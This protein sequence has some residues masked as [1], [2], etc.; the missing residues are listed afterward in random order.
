MCILDV[1]V[2]TM[3]FLLLISGFYFSAVVYGQNCSCKEEPDLKEII[4]CRKTVFSNG[5]KLYRQF[6]CDSSWLTF[7][8]KQGRKTILY[9]LEAPL[10]NYTN[11]L[12]YQFVTEN[13]SSFLIMNRLISGCC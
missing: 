5:A 8:S 4:S 12:G 13:K 9:S 2:H 7:E 1:S 3:R 10:V 6:N 11:R